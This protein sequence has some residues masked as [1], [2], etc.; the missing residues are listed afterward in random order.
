VHSRGEI[1]GIGSTRRV[2]RRNVLK[3]TGIGATGI[4]V[5]PWLRGAAAMEDATPAAGLGDAAW[6]DLAGR[7]EGRLL[8]PGDPMFPGATIINASR[9]MGTS[10][11]GIAVCVS[12]EDAAAC[13]TWARETGAPFAV[14][15]GGH[16]YAGF[17]TSDGLIIDVKGMREVTANPA[18]GTVT[19]AGGA[20]N[21]DVGDALKPYG[22]YF[23]GG[24][25]PSVGVSGLTLGGG[26]GLSCRHLGMTCDSLLSTEIVTANGEIVT[27]SETENSDLFWAVRGAAGGNF[28]VHTSFT[29]KVVPTR[30]V[31]FFSLSWDGG[32]TAELIDAINRLQVNGPREL[33]LRLNVISQSRMPLSQPAPFQIDLVGLYWGPPGDVEELLAPVERIQIADARTVVSKSFWAARDALATGTPEGAY[34][35]KTGFVRGPLA[36]EGIT[37]MLEWIGALPGVPS[38]VQ[39]STTVMYVWGGKVNDLA[40]DANAFVHRNADFLYKCE[41]IWEPQDDPALIA[42]NLD[43]L[44]GYHA[45][46]QPYFSG[47]AYQN[48]PDRTQAD[49]QHAYYGQNFD[50]LVETKRAWDSDNLFTFEQ[51]IPTEV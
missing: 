43:W 50:R 42:A 4:A 25:C 39:E 33:G 14:R 21:A 48:F 49:W 1:A 41:V 51:S 11:A 18:A 35:I 7:L 40:P 31:T 23:P 20:N 10:P 45:A 24:R 47:G 36:A 5:A 46:M 29:Y 38:L 32:G 16:S 8:R 44:E 27:A 12:P 17:S 22:V 2:S 30:D 19:V 37:T 6:D 9:Y 3:A 13:V 26:W 28:G 34:G 15:S